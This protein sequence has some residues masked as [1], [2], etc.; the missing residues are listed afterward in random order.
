M[1]QRGAHQHHRGLLGVAEAGLVR[2]PPPLRQAVHSAVCGRGFLEVQPSG[3]I[4]M[5][6]G[7]WLGRCLLRRQGYKGSWTRCTSTSTVTVRLDR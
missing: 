2:F 1:V 5:R 3:R 6:L 7:R 4:R